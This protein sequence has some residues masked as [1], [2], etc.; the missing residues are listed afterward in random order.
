MGSIR[1][2]WPPR[3]N[4]K[5]SVI[6]DLATVGRFNSSRQLQTAL[7]RSGDSSGEASLHCR[8]RIT[9][10]VFGYRLDPAANYRLVAFTARKQQPTEKGLKR[11]A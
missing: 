3:R 7:A 6:A 11:M 9:P 10:S 5:A 2:G 8:R 1:G 4:Q